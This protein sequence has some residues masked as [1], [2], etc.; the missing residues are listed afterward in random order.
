MEALTK[1]KYIPPMVLVRC[2][3]MER[4]FAGSSRIMDIPLME[5]YNTVHSSGSGFWGG[6]DDA[7][8]SNETYSSFSWGWGQ[9]E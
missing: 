5:S 9:S 1:K 2:I 7:A 4:G 8:T 3:M 6:N